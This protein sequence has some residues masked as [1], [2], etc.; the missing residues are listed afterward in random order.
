MPVIARFVRFTVLATNQAEPCLDEL[1]I[2]SAEPS[3]RNVALAMAGAKVTT[4]G[5]YADGASP[6][7]KLE[8][9]NDGQYGNAR[10]WI[11]SESSGGWVTVE[12]AEPVEIARIVWARDREGKFADRVPTKY[13]IDV[14]LE[15]GELA[16]RRHWR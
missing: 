1:E 16:R 13:R 3:P 10:S 12:L 14:A 6:L 7:H 5:V 15:H 8:H 4:S 2:Y 9:V 11:S